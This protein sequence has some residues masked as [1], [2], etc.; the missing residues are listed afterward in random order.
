MN[1]F[2][3]RVYFEN[4]YNSDFAFKDI[5]DAARFRGKALE[6]GFETS[7]ARSSLDTL[8]NALIAFDAM[9]KAIAAAQDAA[10]SPA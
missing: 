10:K 8:D 1:I 2:N 3:V 7:L 9:H 4:G 5:E 6:A